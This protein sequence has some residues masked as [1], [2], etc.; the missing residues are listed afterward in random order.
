MVQDVRQPLVSVVIPTYNRDECLLNLLDI[1]L[2][3][4]YSNFEVIVF[5]QSEILSC[6]KKKYFQ[7]HAGR[8][9]HHRSQTKGRAVAKNESLKL[10]RGE[11]ILFCDDD[12]VPPLNF[13]RMHAQYH[14]D[15][16]IAAVSFRVLQSD[17]PYLRSKNILRITF[18]GRVKA[19]FHSDCECE[20]E[21]FTSANVSFARDVLFKTTGF[22]VSLAGTSVLEEPHLSFQFRAL[23]Y[24]IV[25]SNAISVM[26]IPQ[27][28]GND[29]VRQNDIAGY[30]YQFHHNLILYFLR[31][32]S[33]ALLAFVIPFCILRIVKQT[34]KNRLSLHDVRQ[35]LKGV[36]DAFDTF[37]RTQ[38]LENLKGVLAVKE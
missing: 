37:R 25:F 19:G 29:E 14:T 17:L 21:S 18:Y 33:R 35:M 23:G 4:D 31:Y 7:E 6:A 15:P 34:L 10:C 32:R 13:V 11:I 1:L 36:G 22:D 16:R 5:D 27:L 24:G 20:T 12:I 38:V 30:Y 28:S 26:H 2:R 8:F 3:Q 9:F